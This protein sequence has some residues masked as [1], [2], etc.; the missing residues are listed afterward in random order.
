MANGDVYTLDSTVASG[1]KWATP[2]T[3]TSLA[4]RMHVPLF[5]AVL[6]NVVAGTNPSSTV[7]TLT[8]WG[9][10]FVALGA[11]AIVTMDNW[12]TLRLIVRAA[13]TAAQSGTVSVELYDGTSSLV[14][15]TFSDTTQQNRSTSTAVS[16][17]GLKQIYARV[18][19]S[20]G[21]DDPQFNYIGFELERSVQT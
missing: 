14:T 12:T 21:T 7:L 16:T 9:T 2:T 5:R 1:V 20:V 10:S 3:Y 18:K 19:S 8:N 13:N 4:I 11:E 6:S 15:L 17:S